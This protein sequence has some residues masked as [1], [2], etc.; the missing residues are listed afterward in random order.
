MTSSVMWGWAAVQLLYDY[1][2]QR[3]TIV[4]IDSYDNTVLST[5]DVSKLVVDSIEKV[6]LLHF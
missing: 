4:A 5:G 3:G 6:R 2:Y 1:I